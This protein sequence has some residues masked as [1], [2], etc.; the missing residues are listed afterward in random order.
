[1]ALRVSILFVIACCACIHVVFAQTDSLAIQEK[2]RKADSVTFQNKLFQ[3]NQTAKVR[4]ALKFRPSKKPGK[5]SKLMT[6]EDSISK[7]TKVDSIITVLNQSKNKVNTVKQKVDHGIDS[8]LQIVNSPINKVTGKVT[9]FEQQLNG[10]ADSLLNKINK[11][12]AN[13]EKNVTNAYDSVANRTNKAIEQI[14]KPMGLKTDQIPGAD[15]E[16][17]NV[18]KLNTKDLGSEVIPATNVTDKIQSELKTPNLSNIEGAN[19]IQD[20]KNIPKKEIS[21]ITHTEKIQ[22][23]TSKINSVDSKLGHIEKL[24]DE[25]KNV[26]KGDAKEVKEAP[27]ELENQLARRATGLKEAQQLQTKTEQQRAMLEKYKDRKLA[28][29]ELRNKSLSIA[30]DKVNLDVPQIKKA[31]QNLEKTRKKFGNFQ[32]LKDIP[33]RPPNELKGKPFSQRFIPGITLHFF[34]YDNKKLFDVAVQTA[35]LLNSRFSIGVGGVYRIA[36]SK[37]YQYHV[38]DY[39]L[40]GGRT[41]TDFKLMKGFFAHAD[42]EYLFLNRNYY[43][44]ESA[45]HSRVFQ[46]D[47]GL[48]KTFNITKRIRG[49]AL[50]LYR[51][52]LDGNIPGQPKFTM[53]VGFDLMPKKERYKKMKIRQ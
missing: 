45:V 33:K 38:S 46:T 23:V 4:K 19:K 21:D 52:E 26:I 16:L 7:K 18:P 37:I 32:N 24:E 6:V 49:S 9:S 13:V 35:F 36:V 47:V 1:M 29:Q 15:K 51:W 50:G 12:I 3:E 53:R 48:G 34:A 39:G 43:P 20:F 41:L 17:M 42:F 2:L 10:K 8:T 28:E 5:Q 25:T 22:D 27:K 11:P 40:Y 30:N 44:I 14:T 31:D